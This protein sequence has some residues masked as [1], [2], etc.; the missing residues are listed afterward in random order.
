MSANKSDENNPQVI[1]NCHNQPIG[2]AFDIEYDTVICNDT[3]ITMSSFNRQE[4]ANLRQMLRNTKFL[5]LLQ[6][7]DELTRNL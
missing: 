3:G 7:L 4:F 2:V 6:H 1:A 5:V